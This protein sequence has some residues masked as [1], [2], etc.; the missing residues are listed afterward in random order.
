MGEDDVAEGRRILTQGKIPA[1]EKPE[2]AV[3][4]FLNMVEYQRILRLLTETPATIPHAF[5]P[6][7]AQNKKIISDI[8]SSGRIIL[9]SPEVKEILTN[10][11]IP[12]PKGGLV[13]NPREAKEMAEEIGYPIVMKVVSPDII[14]ERDVG[15]GIHDIQTEEEIDPAYYKIMDAW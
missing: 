4:S 1:Y 7:T 6:N 2:D 3:R 10:Y 5:T 11:N 8:V 15:G 14:Y 13:N 12:V 9:T